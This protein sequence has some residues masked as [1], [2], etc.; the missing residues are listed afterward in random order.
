MPNEVHAHTMKQWEIHI[1]YG[2]VQH[3]YNGADNDDF[4]ILNA[5]RD[6]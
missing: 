3:E 1:H 4:A 2:D 5:L 6:S